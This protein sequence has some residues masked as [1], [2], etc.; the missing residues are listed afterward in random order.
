VVG[1]GLEDRPGVGVGY[2]R[3]WLRIAVSAV[4]LLHSGTIAFVP[5]PRRPAGEQPTWKLVVWLVLFFALACLVA[6]ISR[7]G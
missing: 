1:T 3:L 6:F 4:L 7:S 2:W 5:K